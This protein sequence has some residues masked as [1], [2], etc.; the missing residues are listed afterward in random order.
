MTKNK[1]KFKVYVHN[2]EYI[3]VKQGVSWVGFF[4]TFF[5]LY[6]KKAYKRCVKIFL[7]MM[8]G[9]PFFMVVGNLIAKY[10]ELNVK[11]NPDEVNQFS[12]FCGNFF[13]FLVAA[14]LHYKG[15]K[16]LERDLLKEGFVEVE[17][18]ESVPKN[19]LFDKK[20]FYVVTIIYI[21]YQISWG[22]FFVFLPI[23]SK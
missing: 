19:L 20:R 7:T 1:K 2:N 4:F 11:L 10:T 18:V 17:D 5:W 12:R 22:L 14:T 23:I 8:I 9:F 15:N 6:Y 21:M 16:W 3:R 13:C